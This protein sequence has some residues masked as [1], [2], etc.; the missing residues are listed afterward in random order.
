MLNIDWSRFIDPKYW[1][2][3]IAGGISQTP[4]LT[5]D[6]FFFS[7]FLYLF[8]GF[9]VLAIIMKVVQAFLHDQNPLQ[10]KFPT[11][12]DN[13]LWMG[14]LGLLWF[15]LRNIQVGFLGSRVWILIGLVWFLILA[16]FIIKYFVINWRMEYKYFKTKV[17]SEL[18]KNKS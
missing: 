6:G 18:T 8:S 12:S 1:L 7:F 11:W 15:I 17:L 10:S 13:F 2:E 9:F 3:G 4:A 16:Y 5:R 14:I